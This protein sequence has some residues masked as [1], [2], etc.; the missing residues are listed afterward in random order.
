M[1]NYL[2]KK[3]YQEESDYKTL[4]NL[5]KTLNNITPNFVTREIYESKKWKVLEKTWKVGKFEKYDL[6]LPTD[7]KVWEQLYI[8]NLLIKEFN[9]EKKS[10]FNQ[11]ISDIKVLVWIILKD[12]WEEGEDYL[13]QLVREYK[14]DESFVVKILRHKITPTKETKWFIDTIKQWVNWNDEVVERWTKELSWILS[15]EFDLTF[16]RRSIDMI[17]LAMK[18]ITLAE[19]KSLIEYCEVNGYKKLISE[20]WELIY[21]K[22]E[23][24]IVINDLNSKLDKNAL[25]L[26]NKIWVNKLKKELNQARKSKNKEKIIEVEKKAT[27]LILENL[28]NYP[29][30]VTKNNYWYQ[31][32]WIVENKEI[33]CIWFCLIWHAFLKEL[34]ITHNWLQSEDHI[35][36]EVNIW[37]K[38]YWF[39]PTYLRKIE[40][41]RYTQTNKI[42]KGV[43]YIL[44]DNEKTENLEVKVFKDVENLLLSNIYKMKSLELIKE[45]KREEA[46]KMI[47]KS[48]ELTP[49]NL[50][51]YNEKWNVLTSIWDNLEDKKYFIFALKSYYKALSM[52]LENEN[53]YNNIWCT[54]LRLWSYKKNQKILERAMVVFKKVIE[55]NPNYAIAYSNIWFILTTL[56]RYEEAIKVFNKTLEL[57]P[58][59]VKTYFNKIYLLDFMWETELVKI[60]TFLTDILSW[61]IKRVDLQEISEKEK[62]IVWYLKNQDYNWLVKYLISLEKDIK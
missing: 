59:N 8:I 10:N 9:L 52:W 18:T 62:E 34:W 46:L 22:G 3:V 37:W 25:L 44:E 5:L 56:W 15:K 39:D 51:L 42:F 31:P 48:I 2:S 38:T 33:H 57:N 14:L 58:T 20:K 43:Q 45:E 21:K 32:K 24:M 16:F 1:Q 23:E 28:S 26:R 27:N 55:I 29:Y 17:N 12:K 36:L 50:Y 41:I 49:D 6:Y 11:I 47:E 35:F 60:Y 4:T 40:E 54:L 30:K 19:Q 7:L 13:L 53:I 61:K